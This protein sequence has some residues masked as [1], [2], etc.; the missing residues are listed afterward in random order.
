[1]VTLTATPET[2][3][4]FSGWSGGGCSGTGTCTVT[5]SS[6]KAVSATFT[7][8]PHGGGGGG[9]SGGGGSS[10]RAS[11]ASQPGSTAA[12]IGTAEIAAGLDR[13]LTP[14]G[15]AAKIAALLKAGGFLS[16]FQ[17]LEAGTA[18]IDW[19][20]LPRGAKLTKA[21]V[22]PIL[23]AAGQ[24]T[25]SAAGT[26]MIKVKLTAAGKRLLKHAKSLKLMA[27][28]TFIPTGKP[29]VVATKAFVLKR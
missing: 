10:S 16:P 20:Q 1:M 28:G 11:T 27:K 13:Q 23:V 8:T 7:A 22:K 9:G 6:E 18:V 25:F 29:A 21:K 17:A 5:M 14:S 26:A 15:K 24:M 4:V 3:S 19:Y 2:G 12:S